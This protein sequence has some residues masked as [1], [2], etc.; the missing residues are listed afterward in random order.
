MSALFALVAKEVKSAPTALTHH[1]P[2]TKSDRVRSSERK[3]TEWNWISR[4]GDILVHMH[5]N[6][7]LLPSDHQHRRRLRCTDVGARFFPLFAGGSKTRTAMLC[8]HVTSKIRSLPPLSCTFANRFALPLY[9]RGPV[10]TLSDFTNLNYSA[11]VTGSCA[12][13]WTPERG[14]CAIPQHVFECVY[15]CEW[16]QSEKQKHTIWFRTMRTFFVLYCKYYANK[17]NNFD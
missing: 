2:P 14:I 10:V 12:S 16:K 8:N 5:I 13:T 6:S 9:A 11:G 1:A 3:T 15:I 7:P 17:L 4:N